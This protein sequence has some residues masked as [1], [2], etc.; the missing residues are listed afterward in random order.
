MDDKIII[1][2]IICVTILI[3]G[4]MLADTA[5]QFSNSS[6]LSNKKHENK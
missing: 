2:F 1:T 5:S 3:L 6:S 4:G